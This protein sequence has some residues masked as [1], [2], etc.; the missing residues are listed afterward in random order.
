[1]DIMPLLKKNEVDLYNLIRKDVQEKK[2][3]GKGRPVC[4]V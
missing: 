3:K 4:I 1:M 2:S